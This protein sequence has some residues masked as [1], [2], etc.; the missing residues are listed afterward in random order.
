MMMLEVMALITVLVIIAGLT[1]Y[2]VGLAWYCLQERR[3]SKTPAVRLTTLPYG[4]R[5]MS[6]PS[7]APVRVTFT[8][9]RRP[10]ARSLTCRQCELLK[11]PALKP[12]A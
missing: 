7:V 10:Q 11:R 12:P 8:S 1:I 9:N 2:L 6:R 4:W 3:Q 5:A